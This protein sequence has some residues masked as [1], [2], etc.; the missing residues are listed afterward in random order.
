MIDLRI[1]PEELAA[2]E[3]A[4]RWLRR[5]YLD[6]RDI[7]IDMIGRDQA[8][9]LAEQLAAIAARVEFSNVGKGGR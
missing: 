2:L 6:G 3:S 9:Q 7:Q 8:A 1:T 5:L 4:R